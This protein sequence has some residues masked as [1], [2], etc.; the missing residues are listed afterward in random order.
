MTESGVSPRKSDGLWDEL[1]H[2][3]QQIV[4]EKRNGAFTDPNKERI[5]RLSVI[6]DWL[7]LHEMV[8]RLERENARLRNT[9]HERNGGF[10]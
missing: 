9:L 5:F 3:R 7:I 4:N 1:V 8:I 10:I 2:T 6:N